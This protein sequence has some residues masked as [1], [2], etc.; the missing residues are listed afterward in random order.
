MGAHHTT[1]KATIIAT[2]IFAVFMLTAVGLYS[3]P[4][5][6]VYQIKKAID[7]NNSAKL[8][9]YIDFKSVREDLKEQIKAFLGSRMEILQKK[10]IE[11]LGPDLAERLADKMVDKVID[12]VVTPTGLDELMRGKIILS[13]ITGGDKKPER[14]QSPDVSM[15]YESSSK[16]VVEIKN[17]SDPSR[18]IKLILTRRGLEWILTAIKLPLNAI[19]APNV[20]DLGL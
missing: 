5:L 17:K 1:R 14:G 18:E 19:P 10:V 11:L 16:F 2:G 15:H 12:S 6:T 4:Y 3:L 9:E 20:S 7:E 8:R 13:Q